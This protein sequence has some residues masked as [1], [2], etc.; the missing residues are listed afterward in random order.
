MFSQFLG[1]STLPEGAQSFTKRF[2]L[3]FTTHTF[4]FLFTNTFMILYAIDLVGIAQAG[5]LTS[6]FVLTQG[7][8]DYPLGVISDSLGQRYVIIASWVAL[9]VG[10]MLLVVA[11][12]FWGLVPFFVLFGLNR[13]F[14]SG[15]YETWISNNYRLLVQE[16]DPRRKIF[17]FMHSRSQTMAR[18]I[19]VVAFILGGAIASTYSRQTAFI[20]Q[21]ILG[22]LF[23]VL[24]YRYMKDIPHERSADLDL[25]FA[26]KFVRIGS[27]GISFLFSSK[28]V[29]F[30]LLGFVFIQSTWT[31]WSSLILF[32]MYFGYTGT[33]ALAGILRTIIFVV[34][35]PINLLASELSRKIEST[36][37]MP[38]LFVLQAI[39]F[40]G[41]F[42]AITAIVPL[43]DEFTLIGVI[44]VIVWFNII[45]ILGNLGQ[46]LL[47]RLLIEVVPDQ[48]RNSVYSLVPTLV[49]VV[50]IPFL[51]LV[52]YVIEEVSFSLGIV[53]NGVLAFASGVFFFFGLRAMRQK[54]ETEKKD[55]LVEI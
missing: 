27:Q 54:L 1:V 20:V 50:S 31:I 55:L 5:L 33:D 6:V 4:I 14:F 36:R 28:G 2:A 9:F 37:R 51:A 47:Q 35:I 39:L 46:I 21:A 15:A 25:N 44:L 3:L 17:S 22:I 30:L 19:S 11:T 16:S 10:N 49:S 53:V 52:G 12:D 45:S 8:A 13:A 18:S 34:G 23:S 24:V 41:G 7:V 32:V 26:R 48:I 42:A 38:I 43:T 40:F 29:F